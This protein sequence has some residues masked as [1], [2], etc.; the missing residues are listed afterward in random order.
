MPIFSILFLLLTYSEVSVLEATVRKISNPAQNIC[1][2]LLSFSSDHLIFYQAVACGTPIKNSAYDILKTVS[3]WHLVVVSAGHLRVVQWFCKKLFPN[4]L[5]L[6]IFLVLLF[7]FWTGAQPP[8]VRSCVEISSNWI[9]TSLKLWI[10]P[11]YLTL[12]SGCLLLLIFPS[13]TNSWSFL[14]SWLCSILILLLKDLSIIQQCL[15][16]SLGTLPVILAFNVPHPLSFLFNAALAPLIS[17]ILFPLTLLMIPVPAL[18]FITD[19]CMDFLLSHLPLL[20]GTSFGGKTIASSSTDHLKLSWGYI[21]TLQAYLLCR[22]T[23]PQTRHD[24]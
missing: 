14:L 10:P 3:L 1:K 6:H 17:T 4:S 21:L 11:N 18:H 12:Y 23:E 7:C 15:G 9:S 19:P 22:R 8:I 13:W 16:M 2:D 24:K 5:R 20:A